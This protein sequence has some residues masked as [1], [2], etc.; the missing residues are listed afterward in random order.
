MAEKME[1]RETQKKWQK[2]NRRNQ[3]S[4]DFS[5]FDTILNMKNSNKKKE[6]GEHS[7]KPNLYRK[8]WELT[9]KKSR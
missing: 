4:R 2:K 7:T 3:N 9:R 5:V 8:P 1:N 6:E